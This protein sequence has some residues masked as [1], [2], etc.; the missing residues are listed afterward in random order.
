MSIAPAAAP[1]ETRQP[2]ALGA[3]ALFTLALLAAVAPF[4][5]DLYLPAFP[6]MV[7]DLGTTNAGVQLSLTAFLVGAGL[8]QVLFGPLSDRFGRRVPLLAG[9]ALYVLASAAAALAPT[10]T[11]LVVAR[12]VQGLTGAAGMV[13]GRAMIADV[14]TGQAAARALSIMMLVGGVAPVVA[15]VVGSVLAEPLGWRGL[16]WIVAALGVVA[17][18][19]ALAVLRETHSR[20]VGG[21]AG[22]P[23]AAAGAARVPLAKLL[24]GR[25]YAGNT[26]AFAFAF[27][28]MMAYISASPFLYQEMM[29]FGTLAYG[30]LF[31][32]NALGLMVL[33]GVSAK[34][35]G[36]VPVR[37]LARTGLLLNAAAIAAMAVV[38]LS[39]APVTWLIVPIFVAV[40]SLG[41]VFGTTTALA[42]DAVRSSA[43]AGSALLG[44]LQFG[45]AG[46]VAP[47]V[48]LGGE[49]TALPL[50]L[51][52]LVATVVANVAFSW[53]RPR[54]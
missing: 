31:G 29:G 43:G 28:T 44:L 52:M 39:G 46:A 7:P 41:L 1:A 35:A 24:T 53:G 2:T 26:V 14:A 6:E 20:L 32:A 12:L 42:L 16:L 8:G 27:A 36:S 38:V 21:A 3:A 22:A 13:I 10:V 30:L 4:A 33:S 25:V 23:A 37:R 50:V 5:T 9:V 51:S 15:P 54:D 49:G 45:L 17:L 19:F 11:L 40:A 34:L 18:G 47:L 48:S